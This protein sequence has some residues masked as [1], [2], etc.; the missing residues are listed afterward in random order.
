MRVVI[1][2]LRSRFGKSF[3]HV[4]ASTGIAATHIA[5][6]TLHSFSGMGLGMGKLEALIAKVRKNKT[7]RERWETA[8]VLI[9][10]EVSMVGAEF[11]E[12]LNQVGQAGN[13]YSISNV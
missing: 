2:E 11:F 7:S 10:D 13:L 12:N 6:T 9:V 4:T 5:G 3:V 1:D 8:R